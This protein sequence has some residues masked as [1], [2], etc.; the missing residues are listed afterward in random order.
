MWW[1]AE[2]PEDEAKRRSRCWFDPRLYGDWVL[3][4][5]ERTEAVAM[6][7]DTLSFSLLGDFQCSHVVSEADYRYKT[8]SKF[9]NG[10][11]VH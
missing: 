10:W 7:R 8:T 11:S 1:A 5:A 2:A 6:D 9:R 3:H 4:E